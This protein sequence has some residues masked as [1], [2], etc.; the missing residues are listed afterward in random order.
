MNLSSGWGLAVCS[1][2]GWRRQRRCW[3]AS[4]A[5]TAAGDAWDASPAGQ[6]GAVAR[7][8]RAVAAVSVAAPVLVTIDDAEFLDL[9]LA[10]TMIENLAGRRDGQVLVVATLAPGS[11]L[12]ARLLS[13][14]R[15]D[16]LGRVHRADADPDMSYGARAA[17]ARD[18]C[19]DLPDAAVERIA[20]RTRNFAEVF[21]VCAVGKLA[22][23]A[24]ETGPALLASRGRRH[25]RGPA[26]G[27]GPGG[28]DRTGLGGRRTVHSPDRPGP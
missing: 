19:P 16:L 1:R 24:Q 23:L 12:E 26:P 20:R 25:R 15:Y 7:A 6:H 21:A 4:L 14:G 10:V 8:A 17:L 27:E 18:V 28:G 5:V 11:D 2:P 13:P 22:E 3:L 9:G